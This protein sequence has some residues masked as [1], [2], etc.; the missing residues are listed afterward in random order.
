MDIDTLLDGLKSLRWVWAGMGLS[1]ALITATVIRRVRGLLIWTRSQGRELAE[2]RRLQQQTG[3][4]RSMAVSV[5]LDRCDAVYKNA[6]PNLGE[7]KALP[8]FWRS[9][10][11]CYYP[12]QNQPELCLSIGRLLVSAQQVAHRLDA[13]LRRP[14]FER[15]GRMRLRQLQ[16]TYQWYRS[17]GAHKVIAV[18]LK[19]RQTIRVLRHALRLF[20][21]DPL[22]WLAYLSQR[23]AVMMAVRCMLIDIYLFTG[24]IAIEAFESQRNATTTVCGDKAADIVLDAYAG[25]LASASPPMPDEL[26]SI[27]SEL[28]GLP[29]RLWNPP[30]IEEWGRAVERAAHVVAAGYFPDSDMPLSEATCRALLYRGLCWLRAMAD[31]RRMSVV[32]PLYGITLRRLFQVKAVAESDLLRWTGKAAGSVWTAWRWARW[33]VRLLRWLRR[34]SPAGVA[35]ELGSTLALKAA[36][37]F[38]ARYGFDRACR[39]LD[40]VYRL[41]SNDDQSG[42]TG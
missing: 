12:D 27:R 1:L 37:N 25:I 4:A 11:A 22:V 2:L 19:H 32:R 26:A 30:G 9:V 16:R 7:L 39:E 34:R 29:D 5:V 28:T 8:S 10:A 21:F 31:A 17:L 6:S 14:G 33:P 15:I 13:L 38:L 42:T 41:S 18:L 20:A 3:K 35:V 24:K 36:L 40:I 23:L